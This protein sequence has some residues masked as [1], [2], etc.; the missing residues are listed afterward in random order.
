M[1]KHGD[2]QVQVQWQDWPEALQPQF[3]FGTPYLAADGD[4]WQLCQ[5]QQTSRYVY[6][7]LL[8]AQHSTEE[9]EVPRLCIGSTN[10][11]YAQPQKNAPW[12]EPEHGDDRAQTQ[13]FVPL[14]EA[15]D[16]RQVLGVQL[17]KAGQGLAE[18]LRSKERQ[19]A[20]LT[21]DQRGFIPFGQI[22]VNTPTQLRFFFTQPLFVGFSSTTKPYSRLGAGTMKILHKALLLTGVLLFGLPA[23]AVQHAFLVQNSGWM[24]PFFT[25][26]KSQLKPLVAALAQAVTT[27]QDSVST[28]AFSQTAGSNQ[29]PKLL[30][31]SAGGQGI[32]QALTPLQVARKGDGGPKAPLADTDFKEAILGTIY[33]PLSGSVRYCVDFYE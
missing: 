7:N 21:L 13:V 19:R 26:P 14:L 25:D 12:E 28:L 5:S 32:A 20:T 16:Q 18:V 17:D 11:R 23:Q 15:P 4:W 10:Y 33:R 30:L 27:E 6:L 3:E 31:Q 22:A 1:R 29:S 2:G 9:A 8:S 24:E